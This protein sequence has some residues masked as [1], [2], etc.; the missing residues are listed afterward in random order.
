M[1]AGGE[2]TVTVT[3]KGKGGPNQEYALALAETLGG[4]ENISALSADTDGIDG[5]EGAQSDP[6][7]AIVDPTTISRAEKHGLNPAKFLQN[8]DSTGFF[9][10]LGDL[11]IIGPTGTNV[12]DF[13][14]I[15]VDC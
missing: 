1:C 5:G 9:G 8:N 10:I 11:V 3:G 2:F 15:L 6:A 4:A 7:G 13:R 14:V 12:N